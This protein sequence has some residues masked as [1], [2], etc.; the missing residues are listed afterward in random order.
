[1]LLVLGF[2]LGRA[3]WVRPLCLLFF[4]VASANALHYAHWFDHWAGYFTYRSWVW[5]DFV[6]TLSGL[7]VGHLVATAKGWIRP[8]GVG[9]TAFLSFVFVGLPWVKPLL[10][11]VDPGQFH[12]RW[13][14]PVC[15]QSTSSTCGPASLASLLHHHGVIV[16]E[17]RIA[18]SC[19]TSGSGSE[20]W[21]LARYARSL[22]FAV[23]FRFDRQDIRPNAIIGIM[24]GGSGHFVAVLGRKGDA[25]E[26]ADP[27]SG[28]RILTAGQLRDAHRFE[29][30]QLI[31][32]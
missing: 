26:I 19:F 1:M 6:P 32:R 11:P 5:T 2:Y 28:I 14:G 16:D 30:M 13:N 18:E 17:R 8:C 10:S 21:Y 27:L 12:D 29:G 3:A 20:L 15:L 9:V 23:E 4:L 22:G 31:L 24:V 7:L 25:W